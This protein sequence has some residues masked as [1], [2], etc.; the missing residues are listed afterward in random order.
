ML[1]V[2]KKY[3]QSAAVEGL[4]TLFMAKKELTEEEYADWNSRFT[5]A[6][7]SIKNREARLEAINAQ[8]ELGLI[9]I[10]SSAIEDK[11]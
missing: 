9:L 4:R 2:T 3:V 6:A 8:I 10:G 5:E 1:Q 7:T 11:L